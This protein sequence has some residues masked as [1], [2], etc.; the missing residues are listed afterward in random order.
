MMFM[1][2]FELLIIG[3]VIAGIVAAVRGR[4][5]SATDSGP[6]PAAGMTLDCPHCG[7]ETPA[8]KH[9]CQHCGADL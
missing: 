8:D 2:I 7:R 9:N 3:L 1:G 4:G 5:G 6:P